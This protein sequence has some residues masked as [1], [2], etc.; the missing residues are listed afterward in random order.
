[1]V[2]DGGAFDFSGLGAGNYT[3][4]ITDDNGCVLNTQADITQPD[5]LQ[6]AFIS[7]Q[8]PS[9]NGS[10]DGEIIVSVIGGIPPYIFTVN[11]GITA[12]IFVNG[13]NYT[14]GSLGMEVTR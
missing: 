14:F 5:Q 11:G 2:A 1:M 13:N 6:S 9:C 8:D 12:P 4:T 3:F 10:T 7:D